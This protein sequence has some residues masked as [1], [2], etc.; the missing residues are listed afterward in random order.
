[1]I[2]QRHSRSRERETADLLTT[3]TNQLFICICVS[4]SAKHA[5][6]VCRVA[7]AYVSLILLYSNPGYSI[8]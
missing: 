7:C 4:L 3:P 6:F 5:Q 8:S 2:V 1:M